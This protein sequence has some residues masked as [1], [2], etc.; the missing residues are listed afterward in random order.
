MLFYF[1]KKILLI[2]VFL[3]PS[4]L[5]RY[6]LKYFQ[7]RLINSSSNNNESNQLNQTKLNNP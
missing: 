3:F 6:F 5:R 1:E 4:K 2:F 7:N